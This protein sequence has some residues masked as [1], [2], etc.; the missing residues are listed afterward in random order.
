[1]VGGQVRDEETWSLCRSLTADNV[2]TLTSTLTP[3]G[4]Y[5]MGCNIYERVSIRLCTPRMSLENYNAVLRVS[6]LELP[7]LI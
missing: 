4:W 2:F 1:M 6:S 7:Q 3:G 5:I